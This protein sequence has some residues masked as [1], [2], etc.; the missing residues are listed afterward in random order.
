LIRK[1]TSK[2]KAR[3]IKL[4]LAKVFGRQS[5]HKIQMNRKGFDS[6]RR[7]RK[8]KKK[9]NHECA[10]RWGWGGGTTRGGGGYGPGEGEE[11]RL[12]NEEKK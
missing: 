1:K 12:L 3:L 6:L 9:D 5:G 11:H 10:L 8:E 2:L 4:C 7:L